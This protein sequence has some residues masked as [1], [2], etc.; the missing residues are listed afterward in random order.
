MQL[1]TVSYAT[2]PN[3]CEVQIL[4]VYG[5]RQV[6]CSFEGGGGLRGWGELLLP[7]RNCFISLLRGGISQQHSNIFQ[8]MQPA[9]ALSLSVQLFEWNG[10]L[11]CVHMGCDDPPPLAVPGPRSIAALVAQFLLAGAPVVLQGARRVRHALLLDESHVAGNLQ[12]A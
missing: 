10:W 4:I 8:S 1:S 12:Q 7:S 11:S 5:R 3:C 9:T 6:R 2:I